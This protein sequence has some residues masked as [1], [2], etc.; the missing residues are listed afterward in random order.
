MSTEQWQ[1]HARNLKTIKIERGHPVILVGQSIVLGEVKAETLVHD[2]DPADPQEKQI[3]QASTSVVAAKSKA[4]AK[5]QPRE[6]V[7][8]TTIPL[9][10]RRWIDIEPSKQDLDSYDLS[11]KVINLPRHNQTLYS[12]KGMEQLNFAR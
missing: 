11:K 1:P 9:R 3:P 12:E 8:T 6:L 2:E 4:K 10:E 7:G 5:L